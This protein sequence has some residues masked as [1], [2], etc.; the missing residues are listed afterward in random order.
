[1]PKDNER[2]AETRDRAL[3]QKQSKS[4][5]GLDTFQY[6]SPRLL[7]NSG[8][9]YHKY[10]PKGT[11]VPYTPLCI[12]APTVGPPHVND[13]YLRDSW[14]GTVKETSSTRACGIGLR[15]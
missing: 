2:L 6:Y 12:W 14:H 1:M 3:A 10:T 4:Y 11:L 5:T 8:R 7:Y 15:V 13:K 9:G